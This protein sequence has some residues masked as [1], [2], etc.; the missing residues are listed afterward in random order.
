MRRQ[1]GANAVDIDTE[2]ETA[3]YML[4][5]PRHIDFDEIL[6]ASKDAGY[7]LTGIKLDLE[8]EVIMADCLHCADTVSMLTVGET[9]QSFELDGEFMAGATLRITADVQGWDGHHPGLDV[10]ES[11][12]RAK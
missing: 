12:P 7:T 4:W 8:G 1:L 6:E 10:L 3:S 2:A 11:G 5:T 9:G